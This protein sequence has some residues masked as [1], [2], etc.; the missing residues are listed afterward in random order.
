LR[1]LDTTRNLETSYRSVA[2]FFKNAGSDKLK[3]ISFMNAEPEQLKD[4]DDTR[5]IDAVQA[6]LVQKYDRLD[7]RENYSLLV[8]P[9]YLGSKQ[10]VEKWAKDRE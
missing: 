2:L 10:V 5:F 1:A 3:N 9:G 4:L 8:L 6:E 7:L